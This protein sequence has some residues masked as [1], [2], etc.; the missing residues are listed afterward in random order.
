MSKYL[1]YYIVFFSEEIITVRL[2]FSNE[3]NR[4]NSS[5]VNVR[6]A[7]AEI[8]CFN[9]AQVSVGEISSSVETHDR[10]NYHIFCAIYAVLSQHFHNMFASR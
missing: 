7:L 5:S 10:Q 2:H 4:Y 3:I 9:L 6:Q 8:L 1:T